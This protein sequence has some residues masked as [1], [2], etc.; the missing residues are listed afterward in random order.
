[1]IVHEDASIS[2]HQK[3]ALMIPFQGTM[4]L[5]KIELSLPGICSDY[6]YE[7]KQKCTCDL[8]HLKTAQSMFADT[9][10]HLDRL[11]RSHSINFNDISYPS[12]FQFMISNFIDPPFHHIEHYLR[13][14]QVYGTIGIHPAHAHQSGKYIRTVEYH[15]QHEKIRAIGECGLD[16]TKKLSL[17][18]QGACFM[19]H[20]HLAYRHQIPIVIH[21]REMQRETFNMAREILPHYHKIHLHC[22][23][24][25][26]DDVNM[27]AGHF[28]HLKFGFTNKIKY[29]DPSSRQ[30]KFTRTQHHSVIKNLDL[31]QILLETD[32][33]YFPVEYGEKYSL[34][35]ETLT[36]AKRIAD[37]KS[38]KVYD[39]LAHVMENVKST[40]NI[41]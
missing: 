14:P 6:L 5:S 41:W 12:S 21:C 26:M 18:H 33:P 10:V 32:S 39:V 38:I 30:E 19:D 25:T 13:H 15:L 17:S 23:T 2:K 36:V 1:M 22:F 34:P 24:G 20:L 8:M 3:A 16:K 27:W 37:L 9:H 29:I 31:S 40:Y 11:Y 35:G 7:R 28:T 4:A